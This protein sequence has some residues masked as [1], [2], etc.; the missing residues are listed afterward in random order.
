[1][2]FNDTRNGATGRALTRVLVITFV[3]LLVV[4]ACLLL[5]DEGPNDTKIAG[6]LGAAAAAVLALLVYQG[7]ERRRRRT[8]KDFAGEPWMREPEPRQ[9]EPP[10]APEE[11]APA[12]PRHGGGADLDG[13]LVH[14]DDA[15]LALHDLV[16]HGDPA[17]YG[18]LPSLLR[19]AGLL[20]WE[21]PAPMSATKLR[22]NGRWWLTLRTDEALSEDVYDR[23]TTLEAVLNVNDDLMRRSWPK[24]ATPV[25]RLTQALAG[26]AD[27]TPA[28]CDRPLV[29]D[30]LDRADKDGEWSCRLRLADSVENL[31]APFRIEMAFQ[32]NL[33]Q[34]VIGIDVVV[35]RPGCLAFVGLRSQAAWAQAYALRIALLLAR[36]AFAS[37]ERVGRVVV[38]CH[39]HAS[40]DVLMS[41]DLTKDALERLRAAARSPKVV[42][43]GLPEDP[44]LRFATDAAGWLKTVEPF[45]ALDDEL[46]SP[47]ARWRPTELGAT[48]CDDAL[49]RACGAERVCDLG[50]MEKAGRVDAWNAVVDELGDTT[51]GAVARLMELRDQTGDL[52]VAE[53]CERASRAL[54]DGTADVSDPPALAELFVDGGTLGTVARAAREALDADASPDQLERAVGALEAA[55]SPIA[56]TGLYLDDEDSVYRYFNSVAERVAYNL[57][58]DDGGRRVRLVPDEYYAAHSYASRALTLLGRIPEALAHADELMRVAPATPD[59]A[60]AKVRCLEEASRVF[61]AA[62]LLKRTIGICPSAREMAICFYRL[63]FME[64]KL[65]RSDLAVACYQRAIAL[66]EDVA[67]QA[68]SELSDLLEVGGEGLRA[69]DEDEVLP[70][71]ERGEIPTG[72]FNALRAR[73]G[74]A[75]GA[76]VDAGLFSAARPLMGAYLELGRDD[77]LLDVYRSLMRP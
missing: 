34:G 38:N 6:R 10:A 74:E 72:D 4:I 16:L 12:Q 45:L 52:T 48:R 17:S 31:P 7:M 73:T 25:W 5:A 1:M 62:D 49:A 68:R 77:A 33:A 21:S 15:L 40:D 30:L 13:M 22:R 53:A 51:Q 69:L 66:H 26:V 71:L 76:C 58:A 39:E 35:P 20:E 19:R 11:P 18:M 24:K 67:A 32:A 29:T 57:S 59:A 46:L 50:I 14:A 27:L 2:R 44:S 64:W 55:L 42:D 43:E 8:E 65:G 9:D 36:R 3:A 56:E 75:V 63:A 60:L 23:L 41:L 28:S 37:S 61:E 47:D 54:V 70:T